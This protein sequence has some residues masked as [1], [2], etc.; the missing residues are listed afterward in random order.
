MGKR[1][2]GG[3]DDG[4]DEPA[5]LQNPGDAARS[6]NNHG[7]IYAIFRTSNIDVGNFA[8]SKAADQAGR[9]AADEECGGN[10]F[11]APGVF[12]AA[13]DHNANGSGQNQQHQLLGGI[14]LL[15][16][17]GRHILVHQAGHIHIFYQ[18]AAGIGLHF[19]SIAENICH[20][21]RQT[22]HQHHYP[23]T[24]A[25]EHWQT[26]NIMGDTHCI[27]IDGA[28][29]KANHHDQGG[30]GDGNHRIIP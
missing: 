9:R 22:G 26:S 1:G 12:G 2:G 20:G 30:G 11:I 27:D 6:T 14:Q 17:A 29:G 10:R 15:C 13:I 3:V 16:F 24:H 25:R 28:I 8:R 23:V 7:R 19:G 4:I 5:L 21:D 18:A